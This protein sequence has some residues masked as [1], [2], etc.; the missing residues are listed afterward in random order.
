MGTPKLVLPFGGKTVIGH[1]VDQ[2]LNA[3]LAGVV[4]VVG[5]EHQAIADALSDRPV[6]LVVNAEPDAEMLSSVRVGLQALPA[7]AQA[8][9]VVLGDQ[10]SIETTVIAALLQNFSTTGKGLLLPTCDNR[11]GHPL[12]V[13]ARYFDEIAHGYDDEGLRGLVTAHPN[14]LQDVAVS[15]SGVL[16]DIDYPADYQREIDRLAA[17]D[18]EN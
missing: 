7:D 8:A 18:Q 17:R 4:V 11:R 13:S 15:N 5:G 14:D 1:V 12:L 16:F 10:P 6:K 3:S 2:V 9:L